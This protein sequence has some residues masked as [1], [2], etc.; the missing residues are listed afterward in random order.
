MSKQYQCIQSFVSVA[1]DSY[2]V[3]HTYSQSQYN[4]LLDREQKFFKEKRD[5]RDDQE[6]DGVASALMTGIAFLDLISSGSDNDNS[7][8]SPDSSS[9]SS[10]G[11]GDFDGGGASADW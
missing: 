1:L 9:D 8:P 11:G 6:D 3:G 2:V 7:S 5:D 4:T 10:Y